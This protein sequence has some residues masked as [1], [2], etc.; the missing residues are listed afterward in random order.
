M[1]EYNLPLTVQ[2]GSKTLVIRNK[3]DYR[4]VLD[5]ISALNDN[6][7]T[8]EEKAKS[9]LIIFYE[10][11][12]EIEDGES[13]LSEMF[14]ILSNGEKSS[15]NKPQLMN[16]EK[17]FSKIAP[18]VSKNLGY[19]VREERFTHWWTFLGAYMEIS[20][21]C[22]FATLVSIRNKKIKG[23]KLEKWEQEYATE[24]AEE[25]ALPTNFTKEEEEFMRLFE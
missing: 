18:P 12:E 22:A 19:D 7:L 16:W 13:A 2:N 21:D 3:C 17:D 8:D 4:V 20:G 10:N 24:H 1:I 6:E 23:K 11:Y 14:R 15:S 9:A 25:L 5:V